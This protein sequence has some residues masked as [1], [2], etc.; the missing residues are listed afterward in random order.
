MLC[1]RYIELNPVRAGMCADPADY[2]WSSY[3]HHAGMAPD[4]LVTEHALFWSLANTPFG[5]EAAYRALV[6]QG[7]LDREASELQAAI[8]KGWAVGSPGFKTILEK[9][10]HRRVTPAKRG[11]PK[12]TIAPNHPVS[13]SRA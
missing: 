12:K 3:R 2:R 13:D 5:R 10:A 9:V 7:V 8:N 4:K 11:R 1:S 6:A